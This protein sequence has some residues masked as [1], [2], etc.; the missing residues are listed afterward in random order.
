MHF[1]IVAPELYRNRCLSQ[2]G[3]HR[4]V[5]DR[6]DQ[7]DGSCDI[8]ENSMWTR[9]GERQTAYD[10]CWD[11]H[12]STDGLRW[13]L[14]SEMQNKHMRLENRKAS[15]YK[16]PTR[17]MAGDGDIRVTAVN[18]VVAVDRNGLIDH[19]EKCLKLKIFLAEVFCWKL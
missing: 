4:E 2:I 6:G 15:A 12:N 11:E 17:A 1:R 8:V 10:E 14:Q 19:D 13:C 3:A 18:E 7:S 16:V 9:S 5:C